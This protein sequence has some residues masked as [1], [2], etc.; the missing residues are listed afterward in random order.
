MAVF[1]FAV[2]ISRADVAFQ[3]EGLFGLCVQRQAQV[4]HALQKI[5]LFAGQG[6]VLHAAAHCLHIQ[7][8]RPGTELRQKLQ[9]LGQKAALQFHGY[10][11][12]GFQGDGQQRPDEEESRCGQEQENQQHQ[13]GALFLNGLKAPPVLLPQLLV[14]TAPH[15]KLPFWL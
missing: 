14:L 11:L 3:E 2:L 15:P 4:L 12:G 7:I 9:H 10:L 1:P 5:P 13:P 6:P 8:P